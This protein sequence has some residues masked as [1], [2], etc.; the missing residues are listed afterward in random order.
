MVSFNS[1][2]CMSNEH[3]INKEIISYA[4]SSLLACVLT[5][6]LQ[7]DLNSRYVRWSA[8]SMGSR[9]SKRRETFLF[10]LLLALIFWLAFHDQSRSFL[11]RITENNANH[12]YNQQWLNDDMSRHMLMRLGIAHQLKLELRR[13]NFQKAP[14]WSMTYQFC[15]TM[16]KM[17]QG[18]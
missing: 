2:R 17:C 1:Q 3:A 14:V 16:C 8:S 13:R 10:L 6:I 11:E 9:W 18:S 5:D 15:N 4:V 7:K 12:I